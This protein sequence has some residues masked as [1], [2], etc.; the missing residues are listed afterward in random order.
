M[1]T[2]SKGLSEAVIRRSTDNTMAKWKG[3]N[4]Y[5]QITIQTI[6]IEKHKPYKIKPK[7]KLGGMG[8]KQF[9]FY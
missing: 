4:N 7:V 8:G 3:T 2:I 5:Q 9:L 1:L 6:K